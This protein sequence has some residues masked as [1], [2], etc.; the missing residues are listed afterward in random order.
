MA[1]EPEAP[2]PCLNLRSKDMYYKHPT[3]AD[4]E[5][6]ALVAKLYG[7]V[8]TKAYWCHCTQAGRG[9]DDRPVTKDE[10]SRTGR[11]CYLGLHNLV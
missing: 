11:K 4:A 3:Q 7:T 6:A 10:C 2:A 1:N 8:D 5:Q 9:P